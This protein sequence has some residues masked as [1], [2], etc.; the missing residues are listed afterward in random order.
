MNF[1]KELFLYKLY[2]D[3]R[4]APCIFDG[5]L[6]LA[7][8]G[9]SVR[10]CAEPGDV[11]AGIGTS[12]LGNRLIYF[13]EVETVISGEL[14]Y[15]GK[16]YEARLDCVYRDSGS[17]HAVHRGVAYPS[18]EETEKERARCIRKDIGYSSLLRDA[19]ILLSRDFVYF[20][21]EGTADYLSLPHLSWI[22]GKLFGQGH[23]RLVRDAAL[24]PGACS[25]LVPYFK[26]LL[27]KHGSG[28]TAKKPTEDRDFHIYKRNR[29]F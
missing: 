1:D 15:S 10:E 8:C 22:P 18:F 11:W 26:G 7:I 4:T 16:A 20:G 5:T 27:K 21:A 19:R 12:E 24:Y 13:A 28:Y 29:G 23:R 6:R 17:G 9:R 25:S 14:Y 3:A 2:Y